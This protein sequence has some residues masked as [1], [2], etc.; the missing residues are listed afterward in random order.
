MN[1]LVTD[2]VYYSTKLKVRSKVFYIY[3][4]LHRFKRNHRMDSLFFGIWN[5]IMNRNKTQSSYIT[6]NIKTFVLFRIG[7]NNLVLRIIID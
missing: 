2:E 1:N 7:S 5:L 4:Q 6:K 3:P